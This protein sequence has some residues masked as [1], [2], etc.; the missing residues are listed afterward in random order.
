MFKNDIETTQTKSVR[1]KKQIEI[2]IIV[3]QNKKYEERDKLEGEKK[4]RRKTKMKNI[5]I[6]ANDVDECSDLKRLKKKSKSRKSSVRD[7]E[8]DSKIEEKMTKKSA[9]EGEIDEDTYDGLKRK[10]RKK[11]FKPDDHSDP[12]K[13]SKRCKRNICKDD[14]STV[15]DEGVC[16][17]KKKRKINSKNADMEEGLMKSNETSNGAADKLDETIEMP[18]VSDAIS[19]K[20]RK[21]KKKRSHSV[22][23]TSEDEK[24]MK[25]RKRDRNTDEPEAGSDKFKVA[26][27]RKRKDKQTVD[28]LSNNTDQKHMKK[29]KKHKL[30]TEEPERALEG[31]TLTVEK[32]KGVEQIENDTEYMTKSNKKRKKLIEIEREEIEALDRERMKLDETNNVCKL[33]NSTFTAK[34]KKQETAFSV[35]EE[36]VETKKKRKKKETSSGIHVCKVKEELCDSDDLQIMSEKKGNL[37]EV[38]ID[39]ARRQAL[40]E[41]I[42]R[43][44]GKTGTLENKASP[45]GKPRCTGTQWDTATFEN[46]EQKNKF[47]RLMGGFKSSNLPQASSSGKHNMALN[48]EEEQKFNRTLQKEFDKALNLQQ[49]RGI[50]LGFQPFSN[51]M[52]KT[53]FIDKNASKSKK[54]DFD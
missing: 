13:I 20:K 14:P 40:Q 48:K 37:F 2:N 9:R 4:K 5:L 24:S 52:N 32:R 47:L 21:K 29:R 41:E 7:E 49:H 42:D 30:H 53:F 54:F 34:G 38:T 46:M 6:E 15:Q 50:G 25:K 23:I 28:A 19:V 11:N 3:N 10:K 1:S 39:K 51:Q 18:C 45:E 43:V 12:Q 33:Q 16:N 35:L 27:S 44:S 26:D 8:R 31:E 22:D 17:N 36:S